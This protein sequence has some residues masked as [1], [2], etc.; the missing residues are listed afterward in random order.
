MTVLNRKRGSCHVTEVKD[1]NRA[2]KEDERMCCVLKVKDKSSNSFIRN[3]SLKEGCYRDTQSLVTCL[4]SLWYLALFSSA[5]QNSPKVPLWRREAQLSWWRQDAC[6]RENHSQWKKKEEK[7][8]EKKSCW[9]YPLFS[10]PIVTSVHCWLNYNR[11]LTEAGWIWT[12]V[13]VA[14][15]HAWREVPGIE[16]SLFTLHKKPWLWFFLQYYTDSQANKELSSIQAACSY[17]LLNIK[18]TPYITPFWI[19]REHLQRYFLLT[20]NTLSF[21]SGSKHTHPVKDVNLNC[22][23]LVWN[24][25]RMWIRAEKLNQSE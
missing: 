25:W 9:V 21:S 5:W 3:R 8:K 18:V 6:M 20:A 23:R 16:L 11:A 4:E 1:S 10:R 2:I 15:H 17:H 12:L 19:C 22:Q 13:P 14:A 7:E 24:I